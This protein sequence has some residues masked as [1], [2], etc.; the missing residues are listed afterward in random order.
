MIGKTV[1]HCQIHEKFG[2]GDVGKVF[3][4]EDTKFERTKPRY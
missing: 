1:S 4:T 2:E 3:L